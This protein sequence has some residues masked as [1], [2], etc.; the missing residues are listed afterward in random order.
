LRMFMGSTTIVMV[1]YNPH[2]MDAWA[3]PM[4]V[5]TRRPNLIDQAVNCPRRCKHETRAGALCFD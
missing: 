1:M 5:S 2:R 3:S 4:L